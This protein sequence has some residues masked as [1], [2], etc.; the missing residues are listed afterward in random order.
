MIQKQIQRAQRGFTLIELMIVVAIIGILAAIALPAYQDY[1]VRARV[2]EGLS[3]AAAAKTAVAENAS[4]GSSSL[5]LGWN[6]PSPTNSVQEINIDDTNGI[7]TITYTGIA[8][9]GTISLSPQSGN[10]GVALAA[11][12]VPSGSINWLCSGGTL[13]A[14][15]RPAN[16]R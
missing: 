3:L 2:T 10:P 5:G 7:I 8:G 13:V 9:N 1:T 6:K 15:Y 11:G 14:K 12:T 16:C 4:S